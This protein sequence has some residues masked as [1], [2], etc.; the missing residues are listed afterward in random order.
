MIKIKDRYEPNSDPHDAYG[1]WFR[2]FKSLYEH[3]RNDFDI[4]AV[5]RDL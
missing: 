3:L 5:I 2:L 1:E 4:M